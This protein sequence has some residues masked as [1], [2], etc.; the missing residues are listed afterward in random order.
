MIDKE[1]EV[2]KAVAF[3]QEILCQL[4]RPVSAQE[5][6]E[7]MTAT[8]IKNH[9]EM[10]TKHQIKAMNRLGNALR[11]IFGLPKSIRMNNIPIRAY[12][13]VKVPQ[14]QLTKFRMDPVSNF[15]PT[16]P[17]DNSFFEMQLAL[18]SNNDNPF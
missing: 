4:F 2:Y 15:H 12:H 17:T 18:A 10:N 14:E 7:Y 6:G 5:P 9:I 8:E 11:S 16:P 13:V 1:S 3:E